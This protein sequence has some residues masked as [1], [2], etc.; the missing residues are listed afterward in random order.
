MRLLACGTR[1]TGVERL[2]L[3]ALFFYFLKKKSTKLAQLFISALAMFFAFA[4]SGLASAITFSYTG[5]VQTWV[6]PFNVGQVSVDASGG[7]GGANAGGV[8]G[9]LGGRATGTLTVT[10]GET[11]YIYV[12][13]GGTTSPA[14]FFNGG[15]AAGTGNTAPSAVGGGGGGAS[16]V[17][18]GGNALANRVIV[19]CGGGGAGG[20]RVLNVGRGSGGGGGG[21]YYG[22][23]GGAAWPSSSST[24][25]PTGGTQIAGGTGGT[26][27][28]LLA[29]GNNGGDGALGQGGAGGTEVT[30]NQA[31]NQAASVGGAGGG[32]TGG[33][34]AYAGNFTGSSGAGGSSY[35][36]G[37]T[38]AFTTAG[39]RAGDGTVEITVTQTLT[40]QTLNFGAAP[41]VAVGGTGNVSATSA[42]PNSGN[43]ITYSTLSTA[44][45]VT[46]A[47]VVTGINA[48]TNNCAIT[49]T[50]AGNTTYM[51]GTATQ[52]FG[53]GQ[54]AQTL[55]FGV[56]PTVAVGGTGNLSATSASPN[57]GNPITYSTLST[58]CSVTAAGVVTGITAGANNCAI[59]ATQAGNTN[60]LVGTASQTFGVAQAAQTLTFSAAPTVAVGGTGN[61][62]ATSAS[63]NSGNPITYSTLST[64]CSVTAAG[65]VT[66]INAGTNNCAITATQAGNSTYLVGTA[67]QTFSVGQAAQTLTFGAAPTVIIGGTG[68]V[69]AT[70]ASPNSGNPITYSTLSTACSVTAAGVVTGINAGTNNCAITATQAGNTNYSVGTATQTFG[71]GQAA[72]T[73]T[74]SAAPTVAVGGTG[75]VGATSASPNSG[76]AITYSTLSTACSVT[77][78]GVVTG[79]NAGANNCAITATQAG[80]TNYL[81]GTATQ[82]FGVG[83]AAQTLTFG[84][85]PTVAVGGTGSVSATSAAPNS[86]NPITYSTTSTA[87][88]VTS[89]GVVTGINAGANNCAITATQAGNANYS[90]GTATQ[91]F[92]V[93]VVNQALTFPVQSPASQ[94]FVASGTFPINP[95]ASSANPNSGNVIVYSSLTASVCSVAGTT[96]T[97]LS[98]GTCTIA[99][100]QAGSANYN[101][102]AEVT[103]SVSLIGSGSVGGTVSGLAGSG[104]VLSLNSGVQTLPVSVNGSFMFPTALLQSNAYTVSVQTQPSAPAQTC[105]VANGTGTMGTNNV[106]NVAVNCATNAFSVSLQLPAGVS[107]SPSA[108]QTVNVGSTTRFT[109]SVAQGFVLTG[110]SGCGGSLAGDVYTTGPITST[111]SITVS[112]AVI[113]T[114]VPTLSGWLSLAL[115]GLL[116]AGAA[117]AGKRNK[118]SGFNTVG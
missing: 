47:G 9:G 76:N 74:F 19:A 41:S 104:L 13:G 99:A 8:V 31:G 30:S 53:I 39:V 116:V 87:C 85:A 32:L 63:P 106:T 67:T 79:I 89:A 20:N 96:V 29:P 70:S 64:A 107:A 94:T 65:V 40:A 109:L 51:V 69:S 60:Y 14:G 90:V 4:F 115:A 56:A 73:L 62:S 86:G 110:A 58:A 101:V 46:A 77:A 108:T 92:G 36:G 93:G 118:G 34:G 81:V 114:P 12:G 82:T 103:R 2:D 3:L 111:C 98:V 24:P 50:Q 22:G 52:T 61:V 27:V 16:D 7:Q 75:T 44:C 113:A 105:T 83:Q 88:S 37:V 26:S 55:T 117:L 33:S 1:F 5:T 66:G 25:T 112:A 38:T 68:T 10:P 15:G 71:I 28:Y 43:P 97:M 95:T 72:Q 49:A 100:N 91:T 35:I 57:S 18:Q 78:A 84:V 48:G 45:S 102:A 54:A 80:N 23:G 11:L 59:T 21:G 17:R 42:S 6:V